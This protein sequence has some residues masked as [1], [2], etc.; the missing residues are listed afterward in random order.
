[1]VYAGG[2][3][4]HRPTR[5]SS[6][7]RQLGPAGALGLSFHL[8]RPRRSPLPPACLSSKAPAVSPR[9]SSRKNWLT[10]KLVARLGLPERQLATL[11]HL[12][13]HRRITNNEY[14]RITQA[15]RPTA[16]RDLDDLVQRGL[17]VLCGS[18]RG[19]FYQLVEKW[20][21]NGSNGSR[22]HIKSLISI[23]LE[24]TPPAKG[25]QRG[26]TGNLNTPAHRL[27]TRRRSPRPHRPGCPLPARPESCH[28]HANRANTSNFCYVA[29]PRAQLNMT[30]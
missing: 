22:E 29:V 1:M 24:S 16:K 12:R 3:E 21:N 26:Q 5:L 10:P 9:R 17:L 8:P 20:L 15:R 11:P 19:I 6:H 18:G 30:R 14:Q 2:D 28:N 13:Q 27:P 25:P 7:R 4:N 23:S